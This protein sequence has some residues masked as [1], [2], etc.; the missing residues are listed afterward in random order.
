MEPCLSGFDHFERPHKDAEIDP[1]HIVEVG[2]DL[3]PLAG[4]RIAQNT[5]L[6]AGPLNPIHHNRYRKRPSLHR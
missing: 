1:V 3:A 5:H 2:S 6:G 4:I